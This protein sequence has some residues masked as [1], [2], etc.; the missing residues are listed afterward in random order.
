MRGFPF[1]LQPL[2]RRILIRFLARRFLEGTSLL[3]FEWRRRYY[4]KVI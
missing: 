3:Y 2:W 1:H 4:W